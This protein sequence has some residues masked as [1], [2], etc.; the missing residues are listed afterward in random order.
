MGWDGDRESR[1]RTIELWCDG[2]ER[3]LWPE[4]KERER[5][6]EKREERATDRDS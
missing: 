2:R 4:R 3:L 6:K 5:E 1:S